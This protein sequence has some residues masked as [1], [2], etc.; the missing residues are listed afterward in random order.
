MNKE[1]MKARQQFRGQKGNITKGYN[2][3][4][5]PEGR[6]TC[7]VVQSQVDTITDKEKV[8]HPA[9][10]IRLR[11]ETGDH[12]GRQLKPF[13]PYLDDENGILQS[14]KNVAAIL[15]DVVPG[16]ELSNG[17]FSV[18][19]DKYCEQVETLAAQC[20]KEIVEVTVKDNTK[21]KPKKDGTPWQN[22][23]INRGLGKD[24]KAV[25]ESEQPETR[26]VDPDDDLD[27]GTGKKAKSKKR[28]AK[29]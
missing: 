17:E 12:K 2:N 7:T 18:D 19:L 25:L 28:V 3:T 20:L 22:V 13:A 27:M 21:S 5:V 11:I 26:T 29:R 6:Y 4:N 1:L 16:K 14:A 23:W 15:G 9:H 8:K 24:A 10:N